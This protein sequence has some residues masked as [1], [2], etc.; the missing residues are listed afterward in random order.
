MVLSIAS[1]VCLPV[2]PEVQLVL[3][4]NETGW[5]Q[6]GVQSPGKFEAIGHELI[7]GLR[8]KISAF[9]ANPS[10][11]LT[12]IF[13]LSEPHMAAYGMKAPDGVIIRLQNSG[14][15]FFLDLLL[16]SENV[17]VWLNT[18]SFDGK[19]SHPS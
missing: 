19:N 4:S 12:W 13:S 5:T 7:D 1:R 6:V 18:L 16:R 8:Q 11:E 17:A 15:E 14:G 2:S 10:A 9:I 3:E